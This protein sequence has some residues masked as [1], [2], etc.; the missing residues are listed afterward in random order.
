MKMQAGAFIKERVE[1]EIGAAEGRDPFAARSCR[2]GELQGSAAEGTPVKA[3]PRLTCTCQDM[4]QGSHQMHDTQK[5][6][7]P[8]GNLAHAPGPK[9][10]LGNKQ[11]P[12]C[13]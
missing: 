1:I 2:L 7:G 10:K 5:T 9:K 12:F 13:P 3:P 11:I 4:Q 8:H 6:G